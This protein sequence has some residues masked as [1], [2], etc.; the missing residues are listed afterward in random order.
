MRPLLRAVAW[1]MGALVSFLSMGIAG[2]ALS[3]DLPV[4]EIVMLRNL[5]CLIVVSA[6]IARLGPHLLRTT[7]F[8]LH[9]ARNTI[10]FGAQCAWYFGLATIPF[11]EVFAIEFTVPVWT[12]ILA[13]LFL[14]ER[15]SMTRMFAICLGLVGILVILRPGLV[16]V[17]AGTVAV[18]AAALGFAFMFVVTKNIVKLDRPVTI[19]FYMNLIQL[20]IGIALSVPVWVAPTFEL[21]PW[22]AIIGAAGLGSHYCLSRAMA[23]ADATV[24]VTLDFI[25][26]PLA[27]L[28][29]WFLYAEPL[30]PFV[31]LGAVIIL[32]GNW[33]NVRKP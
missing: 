10:H 24:V 9:L 17:S 12:A 22:I 15:L 33:L 26:L 11:V 20:P 3:T 19:L 32:F 31:L 18:L 8:K 14:G 29:G 5:I 27:A 6:L 2:R 23:L 21:A 30:S 25:R 1:M 28:L 16:E 4:V 13:T 7:H